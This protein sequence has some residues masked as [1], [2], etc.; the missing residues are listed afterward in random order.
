MKTIVMDAGHGHNTA[1]KRCAKELDPGQ[2]REH[3][4]N[5]RIADRV[6]AYLAAYDCRV[7]RTDDTTGV[8]DIGLSARVKAANA[9]KADIFISIHHNA[10]VKLSA[11][12]G[13]VVYHW[14][15]ATRALQARKLYQAVIDKTGLIGNRSSTVV[16]YGY[17]VLKR[18]DMPAFLLENG[19]MDS[20]VDV[21]II[22]TKEHADK[23]AQG[24]VSFLVEAVSLKP[25][26][27]VAKPQTEIPDFYPAY[28]GA[29]TTLYTALTSMEIDG[30][31]AHRRKI[32][33]ANHISG[34]VGTAA[35][36]TGLYNL[37]VAGLLKK[38]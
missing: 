7:L 28:R 26:T 35:Q 18:T 29:K 31:F 33:I 24:I 23:T 9:V 8:R 20:T 2:T 34:Y 1:G 16:K 13:T 25:K 11:S 21:P 37:L 3:D 10:G 36:N 38:A 12:G 15:N 5:D 32:A 30:S 27:A 22:L 4:L 19:F 17:Y 6:E 14:G